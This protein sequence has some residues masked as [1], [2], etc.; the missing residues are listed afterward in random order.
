[1]HHMGSGLLSSLLFAASAVG[2]WSSTT[3]PPSAL[4]HLSPPAHPFC[5]TLPPQRNLAMPWAHHPATPC[6]RKARRQE[7]V[8]V[9]RCARHIP[10]RPQPRLLQQQPGAMA[11]FWGSPRGQRDTWRRAGAPCPIPVRSLRVRGG[12]RAGLLSSCASLAPLATTAEE[13]PAHLERAPRSSAELSALRRA[14]SREETRRGT[15]ALRSYRTIYCK[16]QKAAPAPCLEVHACALSPC[17]LPG[18]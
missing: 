1:M 13:S 3:Q 15:S 18:V 4:S 14:V 7:G 16:R 11:P 10:C 2:L 17:A 12:T 6:R 5:P 9:P 8:L